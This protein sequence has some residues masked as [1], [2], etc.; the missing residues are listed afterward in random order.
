MGLLVVKWIDLV[1]YPY[2]VPPVCACYETQILNGINYNI[3]GSLSILDFWV[4]LIILIFSGLKTP[5]SN[6]LF[7]H[8]FK[9]KKKK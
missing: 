4:L 8:V 7:M 3:L 6:F 5:K 2:I 1:E 9:Q